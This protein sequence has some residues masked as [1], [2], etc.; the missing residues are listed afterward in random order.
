MIKEA[1]FIINLFAQDLFLEEKKKSN[2]GLLFLSEFSG[3]QT[4]F[5]AGFYKS[6]RSLTRSP[7][8]HVKTLIISPFPRKKK[9]E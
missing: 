9:I 8:S 6:N 7:E 4:Y 3:K 5:D 1:F 2:T